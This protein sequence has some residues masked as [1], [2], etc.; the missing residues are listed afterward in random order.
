MR[1]RACPCLTLAARRAQNVHYNIHNCRIY[2]L[3]VAT[4]A[5]SVAVSESGECGF[6]D[7]DA[8][9]TAL[10][11]VTAAIATSPA[12][13]GIVVFTD[14]VRRKAVGGRLIV[15]RPPTLLQRSLLASVVP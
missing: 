5:T 7:G 3:V 8:L 11:Y 14:E 4:G 2:R 1:V 9:S 13:P 6:N 15:E 12:A 10:L